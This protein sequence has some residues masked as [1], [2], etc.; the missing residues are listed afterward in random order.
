MR[1]NP[2][3]DL[4]KWKANI[5]TL[6][7]IREMA[8]DGENDPHFLQNLFRLSEAMESSSVAVSAL[9]WIGK[10]KRFNELYES[11]W[12]PGRIDLGK[13]SEMPAGSLGKVFADNL[14]AEGFDPQEAAEIDPYP[15]NS[16]KEFFLHRFWQTHDI[17][18]TLCGF[19]VNWAGEL[20]INAYCYSTARQPIFFFIIASFLGSAATWVDHDF[21]EVVE[22]LSYGLNLGLK[23]P[24]I[25][26]TY[27]FEDAW[28]R[29]INEWREELNLPTKYI[30]KPFMRKTDFV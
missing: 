26:M 30:D 1:L 9:E 17:S 24:H 7:A 16:K 28:E 12:Q 18:H 4:P 27:K 11:G 25:F 3:H 21:A 5:S 15:I 10:D 2:F 20:A 22:A 6:L 8:K 14:L 13:L 19:D 23:T 29:P